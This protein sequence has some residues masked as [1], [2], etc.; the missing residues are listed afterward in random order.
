M[1]LMLSCPSLTGQVSCI[2]KT[3][4][5]LTGIACIQAGVG[6]QTSDVVGCGVIEAARAIQLAKFMA[7]DCTHIL[8]VDADI[9][10]EPITALNLLATGKDFVGAAYPQRG[11][12]GKSRFCVRTLENMGS[13]DYFPARGLL[14]VEA[15][16]TG[17]ILV[18]R[19]AIQRMF[20]AYPELKIDNLDLKREERPHFYDL[21]AEIYADDPTL[22]F[23]GRRR[24][25]EDYSFCLR[26]GAIGGEVFVDPHA[27][28]IHGNATAQTR[29]R[30]WDLIKDDVRSAME[31]AA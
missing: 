14:R 30:L 25:G 3:A 31:S 22:E 11:S 28:M 9:G 4:A 10:W 29:G 2:H 16:G 21:F 19:A 13:A 23:G 27:E 7:S 24:E 12:D 17:F 6:F 20:E 5:T 8:M 1:K 15:I 26:W 18:S